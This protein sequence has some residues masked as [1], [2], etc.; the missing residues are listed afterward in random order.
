MLNFESALACILML[1]QQSSIF[2][3]PFKTSNYFCNFNI[4]EPD[5]AFTV[6][7]FLLFIFFYYYL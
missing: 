2:R 1:P 7:I 3:F 6:D 5:Q 4:E